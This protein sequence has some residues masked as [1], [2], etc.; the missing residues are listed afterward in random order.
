MRFILPFLPFVLT[1][2]NLA[3][4]EQRPNII[5]LLADD[6]RWDALHH[7]GNPV[8]ETPN[9]DALAVEGVRF[10][11]CFVTTSICCVSRASLFSGTIRAP[12]RH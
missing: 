8:V 7:A 2:G 12:S 4:A 1:L 3:R 11:Q 6:L 10:T 9:I 5:F